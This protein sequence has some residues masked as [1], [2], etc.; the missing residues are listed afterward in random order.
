[1]KKTIKRLML[2]LATTCVLGGGVALVAAPANAAA[3]DTRPCVTASEW[4]QVH[5]GQSKAQVS[6]ILDG[7]GTLWWT[8]NFGADQYRTYRPCPSYGNNMPLVVW[9]D[10]Y[11]YGW[12]LHVWD[13][14]RA[15]NTDM[16]R[17]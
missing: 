15:T 4:R 11:S 9:Y 1:M 10:D 12:S 13:K 16:P 5:A 8:A 7:P 2:L 3:G 17:P 6:R 14:Y